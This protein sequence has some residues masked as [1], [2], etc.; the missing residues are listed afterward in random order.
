M[1]VLLHRWPRLAGAVLLALLAALPA[2]AN[3]R[4]SARFT[5]HI[6]GVKLAELSLAAHWTAEGYAVRAALETSGVVGPFYEAGLQ[7]EA[8]GRRTGR[9]LVPRRFA[10]DTFDSRRRQAVEIRYGA[11]RPQSVRAEPPFKPKPWEIAPA[12]QGGTVDP[13]TAAL[14]LFGPQ[15][16]RA[17]CGRAVEAF[18]GRKRT[19]LTLGP[20]KRG[21]RGI[22]CD[23]AYRRIA[24]FKP[25]RMEMPEVPVTVW[26]AQGLDGLWHLARAEAP[27]PF[28]TATLRR[29][30]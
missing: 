5:L 2:A 29:G 3:E 7:A 26:F 28:G 25:K 22:R 23:G 9:A 8:D 1:A 20:P 24:G 16:E 13:L 11:G 15:E 6:A 21:R 27:T 12:E 10:A 18:D 4:Y 17:V 14:A 30:G 19:R